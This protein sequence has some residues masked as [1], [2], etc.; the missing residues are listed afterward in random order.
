MYT[1]SS[2]LK[3]FALSYGNWRSRISYT[4]F[5]HS[6]Q[7]ED[8]KEMLASSHDDGH[9]IRSSLIRKVMQN[10]L[11]MKMHI[12]MIVHDEHV[13]HQLQN[14]PWSSFILL[15]FSFL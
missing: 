6:K 12:M 8:V 11:I 9:A 3:L 14:K 13:L 5:F 4:G 1:F 15:A 2:K 10:S 7:Y